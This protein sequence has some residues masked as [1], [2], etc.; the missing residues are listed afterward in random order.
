M[1]GRHFSSSIM[2]SEVKMLPSSPQLTIPIIPLVADSVLLPNVALRIPLQGRSDIA[3]ILTHIYSEAASSPKDTKQS[4]IITVGCVPL[5][6]PA[7]SQVTNVDHTERIQPTLEHQ[8]QA[9][10]A[11]LFTH[12]T[13]AKVVGVSGRR[14]DELVLMVEGFARFQVDEFVRHAPFLE[15]KVTPYPERRQIDIESPTRQLFSQ[16]KQLAREF[17]AQVR[18]SSVKNPGRGLHFSPVLARRLELFI[19]R[20][21]VADAGPLCDFLTNILDCSHADALNVLAAVPVRQRLQCTIDVLQHKLGQIRQDSH[22]PVLVKTLG[23]DADQSIQNSVLS[24]QG[25]GGSTIIVHTGGH[26]RGRRHDDDDDELDDDAEEEPETDSASLSRQIEE[27]KLPP[28]VLKVALRELKKLENI[29]PMSSEYNVVLQYLTTI[30]SLPWSKSTEIV[31]DDQ[32]MLCTRRQLDEDHYGLDDVKKRIVEYI[33]VLCLKDRG[34]SQDQSAPANETALV[35]RPQASIPT[36][37]VKSEHTLDRSPIMLLSGPPGTGKTSLAKSIATALGRKFVRISLGGV[38]H[39][40]DIRGARRTYVGA[41]PGRIVKS[42]IDVGVSNPV[43]LLDEIDKVGGKAGANGSPEAAL[44]EV[45]DPEQNNT[46]TDHYLDVP[47]DLS[48][49]LF[50]ATANYIEDIASPLLDRMEPTEMEGYTSIEKVHIA[51]KYL[52]PKQLLSNGLKDTQIKFSDDLIRALIEKY[53]FEAGVRGLERRIAALCRHKAVECL[54]ATTSESIHN[55][56]IHIDQ[57]YHV[58]GPQSPFARSLEHKQ[59]EPGIVNGLSVAGGYSNVGSVLVIEA[60]SMPG[61]GDSILTGRAMESMQESVV[62]ATSW[63]RLNAFRLGLSDDPDTNILENKSFH[64]NFTGSGQKDGGS[65]GVATTIAIVSHLLQKPVPTTIAMTGT[66]SLSGKAGLIG[67]VKGKCLGAIYAGVEKV[68]VPVENQE[69][70]D[71]LPAEIRDRVQV[72]SYASVWDAIHEIWPEERFS[73]RREVEGKA[74][75]ESRL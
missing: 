31:L 57:L 44:L 7:Q 37:V 53:T 66:V 40:S 75:L 35:K 69:D 30:A 20:K 60:R 65:A 74:Q 17:L 26:P 61:A 8:A 62:V 22:A 49:C 43:V 1:T 24:N 68:L 71:L 55:P 38:N 70:I 32:A 14:K 5:K 11:D 15:A 25:E 63:V 10:P 16:L 3:A 67:G 54:E 18:L 21:H 4:R 48:K 58:L 45:L 56:E 34:K 42:L 50:I 9:S 33:A 73:V 36:S 27:A 19:V 52:I 29:N 39:E 13:I 64:V 12:G 28:H 23:N 59:V 72:V 46:F 2:A 47:F 41:Y 51:N 6:K